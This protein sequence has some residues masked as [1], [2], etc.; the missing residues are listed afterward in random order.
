[1]KPLVTLTNAAQNTC[2][3]ITKTLVTPIFVTK[4]HISMYEETVGNTVAAQDTCEGIRKP[5]V[6]I[7]AAAQNTCEGIRNRW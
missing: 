3:G 1:M 5:L 4:K 2:E 6:T 7:I